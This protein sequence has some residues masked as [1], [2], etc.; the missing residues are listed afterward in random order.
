MR[1]SQTVSSVS[2]LSSCG[3]TPSRARICG[4]STRRV[5]AEH[6]QRARRS[7]GETQPIIRMVELLPAPFGPRK[8]NASP[9]AISKSM[10]STAVNDPKRLVRPRAVMSGS[11]AGTADAN[12]PGQPARGAPLGSAPMVSRYVYPFDHK[13][14]RPPMEMKDLLGGKGANLAEMTSVLGLPVPPGFTISTDACRA[15]MAGGWPD[16]LDEEIAKQLKRLE[17]A[18]GRKS[19]RPVGPAAGERAVGGQVL[20]ARDDGHRPQPRAERRERQGSRRPDLRRALRLRQLPAVRADVRPDRARHRGQA[21][22]RRLRGGQ[23]AFGRDERRRGPRIG[24]AQ[25]GR[26]RTRGSSRSTPAGRSRRSP[27]RSSGAPSRPCSGRGTA[28]RAVAYRVRER[29]P[30]DLGTAVNVQSMV[31]GNRDDN[32]GTGVG[33]TRDPATGANGELRRLPRQ[34]PGRGRRGRHPQHRAAVGARDHV[35]EGLQGAHRDLRPSRGPLPRHVRHGV[36]HRAGQAL[37]APD[38]CRQADGRGGAAHGGRHDQGAADP[39]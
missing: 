13:H 22:R 6:A 5:E 25:A 24:A 27:R 2:R 9:G 1:L 17:S 30:H 21:V 19:G 4:P 39:S 38:P 33:F 37:D 34:R 16:G 20:D 10:P 35:P 36:H 15:Y 11:S 28:P 32:S 3:T 8:P 23:A 26:R 18:M 14:K 31:F 12:L 29:I 7:T